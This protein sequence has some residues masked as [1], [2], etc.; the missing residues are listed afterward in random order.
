[1]P[2]AAGPSAHPHAWPAQEENPWCQELADSFSIK[3]KHQIR[4][5]CI[6]LWVVWSTCPNIFFQWFIS[7]SGHWHHTRLSVVERA[8]PARR[9]T[10]KRLYR[11]SCS[12]LAIWWQIA[13]KIPW[14]VDAL[15]KASLLTTRSS[16]LPSFFMFPASD[17][18]FIFLV[19]YPNPTFTSDCSW[20]RGTSFLKQFSCRQSTNRQ[21]AITSERRSNVWNK[22]LS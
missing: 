8:S 17:H 16:K 12:A 15:T 2:G 6:P 5:A 13:L 21:N 19:G 7:F 14:R 4:L 20:V 3:S 1:M 22:K 10:P 9:L 18:Q 11:D